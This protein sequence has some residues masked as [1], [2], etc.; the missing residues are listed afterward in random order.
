M[1]AK[2]CVIHTYQDD[3]GRLIGQKSNKPTP[4]LMDRL[5]IIESRVDTHT[6][7]LAS[8]AL[9]P[10]TESGKEKL[11]SP[12]LPAAR[13]QGL[14]EMAVVEELPERYRPGRWCK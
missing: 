14:G 8:Q 6:H 9:A 11:N 3:D 2:T 1:R 5:L 4:T 12:R 7:T 10:K 13:D